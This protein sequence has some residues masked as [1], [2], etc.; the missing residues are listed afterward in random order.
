[1][2]RCRRRA[3]TSLEVLFIL[4]VI[5][6]GVVVI[7]KP[8]M[9]SGGD[10]ITDIHVKDAAEDA[11]A[12]LNNGV[13]VNDSLHEPLNPIVVLSNYSSRGF[14]LRGLTTTRNGN[15]INVSVYITYRGS[16]KF[17]E[18]AG[19]SNPHAYLED[20]IREFMLRYISARP[21]VSRNGDLLLFGGKRISIKVVV[22]GE[23]G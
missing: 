21:N 20:Q 4:A 9:D 19:L 14:R 12:Y 10:I 23:T 6:T 2:S 22:R 16:E 15:V 18:D 3:Q 7:V 5:L 17:W 1:M 8:Y 11:C 13:L